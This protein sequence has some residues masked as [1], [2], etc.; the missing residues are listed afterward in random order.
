MPPRK[1]NICEE[2]TDLDRDCQ[3]FRVRAGIM[4]EKESHHVPTQ[5]AGDTG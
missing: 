5:R 1:S 2:V 3:E 4:G